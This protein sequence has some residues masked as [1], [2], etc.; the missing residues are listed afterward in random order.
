MARRL[1]RLLG[2]LLFLLILARIDLG[3]TI[4]MLGA[5][6]LP[7]LAVALSLYPVLILLKAWRWRLLLRQQG[8][9]YTCLL[10]TSDA[11]DE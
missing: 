7:L 11:A 9:N 1:L 6:R 2:P 5:V 3:R 4:Q 10:Y 8:A